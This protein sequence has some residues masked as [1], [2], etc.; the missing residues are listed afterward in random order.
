MEPERH[1]SKKGQE[2]GSTHSAGPALHSLPFKGAE[3][4]GAGRR[5]QWLWCITA[6]GMLR[7]SER[8]KGSDVLFLSISSPPSSFLKYGLAMSS[9]L[10]LNLCSSLL[11][12]LMLESQAYAWWRCCIARSGI[13]GSKDLCDFDP[14]EL[15]S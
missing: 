13:S 2:E 5:Q 1:V 7:D 8:S 15:L 9:R 3:E 4:Y 6:A 14:S 12:P 10:A 11:S